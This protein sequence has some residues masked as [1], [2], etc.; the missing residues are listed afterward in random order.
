[1]VAPAWESGVPQTDLQVTSLVSTCCCTP[2]VWHCIAEK[3][4]C[5]LQAPPPGLLVGCAGQS[6][7]E[8]AQVCLSREPEMWRQQHL[9]NKFQLL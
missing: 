6:V 8:N 1:M 5:P 3:V 9:R 7:M 4:H 2:G